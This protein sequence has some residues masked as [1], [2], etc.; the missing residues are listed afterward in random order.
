MG[1]VAMLSPLLVGIFSLAGES[2]LA[3][4]PSPPSW[5]TFN[6]LVALALLPLLAPL[7]RIP[8]PAPVTAPD[9]APLVEPE[10]VPAVGP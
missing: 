6:P 5:P 4:L 9:G 7:A 1:S 10:L 2:T 8:K 3:W